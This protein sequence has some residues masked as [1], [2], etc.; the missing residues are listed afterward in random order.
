MSKRVLCTV[1]GHLA[2]DVLL[3][4]KDMVVVPLLMAILAISVHGDVWFKVWQWSLHDVKDCKEEPRNGTNRAELNKSVP[5]GAVF[6]DVSLLVVLCI[7]RKHCKDLWVRS[8]WCEQNSECHLIHTAYWNRVSEMNII[9][10]DARHE[11]VRPTEDLRTVT[12]HSCG[13]GEEQHGCILE[14]NVDALSSRNV[15]QAPGGTAQE[16]GLCVCV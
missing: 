13:G 7:V 6:I 15:L 9:H 5:Q 16:L 12:T 14:A 2:L 10:G 4:C 8:T 11:Q 3:A 1:I